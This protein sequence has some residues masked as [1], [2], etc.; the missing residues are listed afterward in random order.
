[1]PGDYH[2][3][4]G[5]PTRDRGRVDSLVLA[6]PDIDGGSRQVGTNPDIGADEFGSA[7]AMVDTGP[8]AEPHRLELRSSLGRC[9]R[10]ASATSAYVE[11]G[12]TTGY[13]NSERAA[14]RRGRASAPWR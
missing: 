8:R 13:G 5:S 7:S 11:Y 10:A 12:P 6:K 14:A 2:Q 1:M 9:F 3:T 4:P